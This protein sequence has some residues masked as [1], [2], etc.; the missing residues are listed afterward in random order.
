MIA[1]GWG[2]IV[3][4]LREKAGMTQEEFANKSGLQRGHISRI[5]LN[6]YAT[7]RQDTFAK[8]AKGLSM[9]LTELERV[10]SGDANPPV[11]ELGRPPIAKT[12]DDSPIAIPVYTEFRFHAPG[13]VEAPID[14]VYLQKTKTAGKNISAF[15]IEGDCMEPLIHSGDYIVVD[16]DADINSGDIVACKINDELH[17][18]KLRKFDNEFW[19]ENNSERFRIIDCQIV[20]K[21]IQITRKL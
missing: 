4:S 7:V 16:S 17:I 3:K 12:N 11:R 2:S 8:L 13:G 15:T 14:Y 10:L 20:A 18:G 9:S 1:K 19:L 21:V 6:D 5:E